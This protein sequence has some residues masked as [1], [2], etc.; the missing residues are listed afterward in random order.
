MQAQTARL[1]QLIN[2]QTVYSLEAV[3]VLNY[4]TA[5]IKY[6]MLYDA[7]CKHFIFTLPSIIGVVAGRQS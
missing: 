1:I 5:A 7:V 3:A 6:S 4:V 2:Q